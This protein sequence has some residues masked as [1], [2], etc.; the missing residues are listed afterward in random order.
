MTPYE[1]ATGSPNT[2]ALLRVIKN[3]STSPG[4]NSRRGN[5]AEKFDTIARGFPLEPDAVNFAR[6]N[7]D[8]LRAKL[9]EKSPLKVVNCD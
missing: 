4:A 5:S 6:V 2:I 1:S 9:I 7:K 8:I 3:A